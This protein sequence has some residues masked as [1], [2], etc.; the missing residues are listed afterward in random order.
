MHRGTAS[1][2]RKG[3]VS[4]PVP[5]PVTNNGSGTFDVGA[6]VE[7]SACSPPRT[8]R[9]A[10]TRR[11]VAPTHCI[12]SSKTRKRRRPTGGSGGGD[13][14]IFED[15]DG[16]GIFIGGSD[17]WNGGYGGDNGRGDEG[18]S[19]WDHNDG[20]ASWMW[21]ALCLCSVIQS[22]HYMLTA[23]NEAARKASG[24]AALTH[25]LYAPQHRTFQCISAA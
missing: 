11:A 25:A 8:T 12:A 7:G 19:G 4:S 16:G 15:S 21:R 17:G 22:V 14:D 9:Y 2:Q 5:V 10:G 23:D 6:S 18:M 24:F 3:R 20:N 13:E 1:K